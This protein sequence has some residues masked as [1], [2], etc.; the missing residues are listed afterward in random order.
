MTNFPNRAFLP[1]EILWLQAVGTL[2]KA[3]IVKETDKFYYKDA[4]ICLENF[5][6]LDPRYLLYL[7]QTPLM[8]MQVRSNSNG[9]TA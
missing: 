4:V 9:T 3:Y 8:D 7:M 6:N 1:Q 5:A 2:G